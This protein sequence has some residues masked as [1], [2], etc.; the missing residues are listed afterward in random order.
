MEERRR[1]LSDSNLLFTDV[2]IEPVLPY[3]ADVDLQDVVGGLGLNPAVGDLVGRALFGGFSMP[4]EPYRLRRHQAEALRQSLQPGLANG[5]N[6]VVTS[7]TGSGKTE[8]FLLPI[9]SRIRRSILGGPSRAHS[10]GV[11]GTPQHGLLRFERSCCIQ[12]MRW[13]KTRSPDFAV[14][15]A[16]SRTMVAISSGSVATPVQPWV[17]V[18]CPERRVIANG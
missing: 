18:G 5:R 8:S 14:R 2:L 11:A 4:G 3:D 16:P 17:L 7:G 15:F 1:L 13:W 12:Q 9:L 10:G 6:V